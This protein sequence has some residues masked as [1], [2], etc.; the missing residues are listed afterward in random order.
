MSNTL[1]PFVSIV[2][3]TYNDAV[4]LPSAIES[5]LTQTWQDFELIVVNDGSTDNTRE[6]LQDFE[7]DPR[8]TVIHKQNEKLPRALNTG[9]EKA[10]GH[11]LTWTSSDNIMLSHML[12]RLLGELKANPDVAV[13]YADWQVI[14]DMGE[15]LGIVNTLDYDPHL[16]MRV[17]FVNACFLYRRICQETIGLYD[18]EYILAEDWEYWW[19]ISQ[20]FAM[21][22][23]PEVLYQYRVH[24]GSLS[25]FIKKHQGGV[26]TG[27]RRLVQ[28][29]RANPLRWY[30]SKIKYNLFK[31][32][33]GT[34]LSIK[35]DEKVSA[36]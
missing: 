19:R 3:P 23:V 4:F 33:H 18:P 28:D 30:W 36:L 24:E 5:V 10:R 25:H 35:Q 8:V 12:E 9:F 22:H 20:H 15:S 29:F 13:A 26:S 11:Y 1:S 14:N 17:N 31:L 21:K 2:L 27:Y 32:R 34:P 16:L 7:H 6:V